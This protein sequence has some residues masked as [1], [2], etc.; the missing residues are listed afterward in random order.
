MWWYACGRYIRFAYFHAKSLLRQSTASTNVC[1][2][3]I[4]LVYSLGT[5]PRYSVA[6][7]TIGATVPNAA[8]KAHQMSMLPGT[9]ITSY[10]VQLFVISAALPSTVS[11]T[12]PY[13]AVPQT[14]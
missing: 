6:K 4:G 8:M 11:K 14:Q 12:A 5:T 9:A 2:Q 7:S 1:S 10:L 3:K 13:M